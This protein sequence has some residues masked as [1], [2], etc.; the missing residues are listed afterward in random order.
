MEKKWPYNVI[1]KDWDTVNFSNFSN[2]QSTRPEYSD[3]GERDP[4]NTDPET[5]QDST[6]PQTQDWDYGETEMLVSGKHLELAS[7]VF[8]TMITGPFAEGKADSS[9]IRQITATNWDPEAFK[10]IMNIIHGYHREVPRSLGLE[11][12]SR[13]AMIVDYYEC[14]ECVEVYIDMWLEGSSSELPTVYGRDCVLYLFIS[15][16][17]SKPRMFGDMA[18]LALR[19]SQKLIET[20]DIPIP[21]EVLG[22]FQYQQSFKPGADKGYRAD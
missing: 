17:F 5:N 13:V 6:S 9:G 3:H 18:Y 2:D 16:V 1:R 22:R 11:M 12:L 14:N 19:H 15:W 8:E 20:E 7:S 21:A 10:I 4:V